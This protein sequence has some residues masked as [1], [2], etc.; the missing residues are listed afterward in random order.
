MEIV[1]FRPELAPAFKALNEAWIT[2]LF[3]LEAKDREVLGDPQGKVIAKGGHVL[4]VVGRRRDRRL[5]RA[6][7]DAG[8]RL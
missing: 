3:A 2:Q 6:D 4:F 7:G 8:R 1:D 5:L